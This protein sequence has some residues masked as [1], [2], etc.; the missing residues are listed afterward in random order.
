MSEMDTV[1]QGLDQTEEGSMKREMK[2]NPFPLR[3]GDKIVYACLIAVVI[4]GIILELIA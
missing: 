2:D 3:L 1:R 4:V